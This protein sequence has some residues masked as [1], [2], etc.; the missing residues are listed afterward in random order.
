VIAWISIEAMRGGYRKGLTS[1][2]ALTTIFT[3]IL[4]SILGIIAM[5]SPFGSGV[6]II[7]LMIAWVVIEAVRGH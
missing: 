5:A 2:M 1:A 7:P 4:L 3:T 6:A